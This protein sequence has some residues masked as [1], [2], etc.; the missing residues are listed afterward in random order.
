MT[1]TNIYTTTEI[2]TTG[3]TTASRKGQPKPE[4]ELRAAARRKGLTMGELAD[5]MGISPRY[6]SQISTGKRPWNPATKEKVME[7]LGEVPG[8]GVV[9][10]QGGH[11]SGETTCIRERAR[12]M[13]MSMGELAEKAG[14][15]RSFMSEVARGRRNMGVKVQQRVEALLQAPAQAAPATS[16]PSTAAPCGTAWKPTASPRTRRQGG[17]ESAPPTSTRS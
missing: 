4:S 6:L 15:S 3:K 11:V 7:V 8:Q 2:E 5:R 9:Y 17:P 12:E 1:A 16:P 10:R 13:G 14:V